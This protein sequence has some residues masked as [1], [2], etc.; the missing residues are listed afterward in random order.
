MEAGVVAHSPGGA[1]SGYSQFLVLGSKMRLYGS[2][3]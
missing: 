1:W 2:H 3:L